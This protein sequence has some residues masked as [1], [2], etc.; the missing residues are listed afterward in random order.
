MFCVRTG[1]GPKHHCPCLCLYF[2]FLCL[3]VPRLLSGREPASA[4]EAGAGVPPGVRVADGASDGAAV[5]Q[6][7]GRVR[8]SRGLEALPVF[9]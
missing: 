6:E 2:S 4:P 1:R 8:E 3:F 7:Q 5:G 9:G